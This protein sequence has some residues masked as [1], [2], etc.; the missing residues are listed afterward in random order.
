LKTDSETFKEKLGAKII[1]EHKRGHFSG[2]DN[3]TEIPVVLNE[4]LKM[5]E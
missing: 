1:V 4:L 2:G 5:I 3:V